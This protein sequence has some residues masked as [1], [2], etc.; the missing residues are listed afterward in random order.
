VNSGGEILRREMRATPE[1]PGLFAEA[2][3]DLATEFGPTFSLGLAAPGLAARDGRS[4]AYLPGRL[5]G[6][7]GLDWTEFLGQAEVVP[8]LNDAQASLLGE[9]WMGA[10]RGF[11]NVVLLT[12]GTGVGGAILADGRL[13][14]GQIGRAGHVG[15]LC[16]DLD[17]APSIAGTPGALEVFCGNFN[18]RERSGGRFAT[19][20]EMLAAVQQGDGDAE[21]VW[22][23][24]IRAL[25]CGI[26]SLI[27]ILDPEA[28]ILGG[29]IAQAGKLVFE[30]LAAELDRVEWRPG[31]QAV[32]LLPATLGEWA[33]AIGAA[34]RALEL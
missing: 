11:Q 31:G 16:L 32:K 23:R 15:H 19:T 34:H 10:A 1:A 21:R 27:N 6:L 26:A 3:R 25:A 14:R 9:A 2:I 29:G 28:V 8:V 17:G 4:I 20:H 5:Q 33:G 13:L 12:L 22:L 24:S 30:P 7:E 18:I